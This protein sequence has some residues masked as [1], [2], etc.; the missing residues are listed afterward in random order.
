MGWRVEASTWRQGG[1]GRR[2]GIWSNLR[3]DRGGGREW[4]MECK[5]KLIK[6]PK[7]KKKSKTMLY[8]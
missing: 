3:V 4:N 5:N 8:M 2:W 1:V 6:N 7:N